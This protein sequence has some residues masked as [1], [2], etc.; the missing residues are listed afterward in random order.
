MQVRV[1]VLSFWR[2][3]VRFNNIKFSYRG[4]MTQS[5]TAFAQKEAV[6]SQGKFIF[7]IRSINHRFLDMNFRLPEVLRE[8]E[9]HFREIAKQS[10]AR[11]KVDISVRFELSDASS[12]LQLNDPLAKRIIDLQQEL[13][14]YSSAVGPIDFMQLLRWPGILEQSALLT[15][16]TKQEILQ[17]F[18][19]AVQELLIARQREGSALALT[20]KSRLQQCLDFTQQIRE[21]YPLQIQQ[22]QKRLE[23]KL[24]D[25]F[26]QV[27]KTRIEQEIVLLTQKID[28]AEEIDRLQTHIQEFERILTL[29]GQS[30]RR[31]DFLLQEMNR[32]ANTMAA[33]AIETK[34]QHNVVEI[35]VL[36]EQI[37]EQVQNI[38]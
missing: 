7:E 20:I 23:D 11:G 33:K 17:Q 4:K 37:R 16:E 13:N 26:A 6:T 36:L 32:E 38:E 30:G 27:D 9:P 3:Q 12:E 21:L 15:D 18:S 1:L 10:L 34:I 31:M 8:L 28:I 22:Q 14:A 24:K 2:F 5:M 35:K 29:D 19:Q 25:I